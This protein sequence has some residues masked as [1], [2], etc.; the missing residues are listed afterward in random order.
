LFVPP[1]RERVEDIPQLA[2][3]LLDRI[4]A[5]TGRGGL[6]LASDAAER[7]G[8][9]SWPG[10]VRE[11]RNALERAALH[12]EGSVVTRDYLLV[13]S[14]SGAEQPGNDGANLTLLEVERLHIARVLQ[15]EHGNVDNAAQRLGIPRS[16][17]YQKIKRHR[18]ALSRV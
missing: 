5:D 7:L 1:L 11:L 15:A 13:A 9:Y 16:S 8:K 10:N 12:T 17:L 2:Q 6:R 18:I 3:D 14:P 4:A